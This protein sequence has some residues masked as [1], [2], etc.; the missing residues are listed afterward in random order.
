ME[1]LIEQ[2]HGDIRTL[3]GGLQVVRATTQFVRYN[4]VKNG[5]V[6]IQ[7]NHDINPFEAARSLLSPESRG[8]KW[9]DLSNLVFNDLDLIPLLIQENYVN[10]NPMGVTSKKERLKKMARAAR[11]LSFGDRLNTRIRSRQKWSLLPSAVDMGSLAPA[12]VVRGTRHTFNTHEMN[13]TRFTGFLGNL[14]TTNKQLRLLQSMAVRMSS[15]QN[16]SIDKDAAVLDYLP[17]LRH[18]LTLPLTKDDA[19]GISVVYDVMNT[20][21]ID[22]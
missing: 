14:S 4:D 21:C 12:A 8:K 17:L 10:H 6:S 20:Y 5:A 11:Y 22:K 9:N 18:L 3:I 1:L 16:Y 19:T 7:K 15:M 2:A 13:F